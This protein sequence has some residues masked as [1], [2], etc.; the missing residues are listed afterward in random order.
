MTP[1]RAQII[2]GTVAALTAAGIAWAAGYATATTAPLDVQIVHGDRGTESVTVYRHGTPVPDSLVRT[3]EAWQDARNP[4]TW[5]YAP[6]APTGDG[7]TIET[8]ES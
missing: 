4:G 7:D 3:H 2:A 8:T 6:P 1:T 5:T